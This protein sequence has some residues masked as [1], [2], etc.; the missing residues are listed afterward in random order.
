MTIHNSRQS[1]EAIFLQ[2]GYITDQAAAAALHLVQA[3]QKPLLI[4]GPAGVGKTEMAKVLAQSLNTRLIRLQC[5]E[6]LDAANALYE[7]NY[8]K[9]LLHIRM[10]ENSGAAVR[11]KEAAIF[12]EDFLLARP[13]LQA[14]TEEEASPVLLIDE[15]D[16][17]DEEFEAFLLE[18]LAEFQITIPELG[19]IKAKHRPF[20]ILTSNRTR[21]LSDAL[22]RRCLYQ[23]IDYPDYE[24][25]SAILQA[26]LPHI[27]KQ[28]A[29]QIAGMMERIRKMSLQKVPGVA[30]SLDWAEALMLLHREELDKKTV[31]ET[32]GCFIKD[33]DDWDTVNQAIEQGVLSH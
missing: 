8:A 24:K 16:R 23:W 19:T 31:Y 9:Q 11:E 10:M 13:L 5:Y 6:G 33:R 1:I 3:L 4:E 20:V 25:E 2:N 14:L 29:D 21:E 30:E 7:W 22:R 18:A 12:S 17:A 26:R 28:L 27:N 15:V 32:L